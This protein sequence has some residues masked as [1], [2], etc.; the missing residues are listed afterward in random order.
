MSTKVTESDLEFIDPDAEPFVR[1]IL[2]GE[3]GSWKTVTAVS[4]IEAVSENATA[5]VVAADDGWVSLKNH[6]DLFERSKIVRYQGF[7]QLQFLA[8]E[9]SDRHDVLVI[10][11]LTQI[12]EEYVDFLMDNV[13]WNGNFREVSIPVRGSKA[14]PEETPGLPDYHVLRNKIRKP[15]RSL[16][17]APWDVY[18]LCHLR[19]PTF[20]E[21]QKGK[22]IRRPE[23]TKRVFDF[24]AREAHF[25]G[26]ME[27]RDNKP[28]ATITFKTDP[29]TIAKSRIAGL[30]DQTINA[31]DLPTILRKW[32]NGS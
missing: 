17:R 10:D 28:A 32:K 23:V 30:N 11:T 1:G 6:P 5:L 13:K 26:F 16:M 22:L 3:F 9:Y 27:K 19:E 12:C 24:V 18:F 31:P 2:Y 15:L 14:R 20:M 25:I 29:K 7:S 4:C 21:Q 8:D